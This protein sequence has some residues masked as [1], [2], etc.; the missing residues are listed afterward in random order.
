MIWRVRG[1]IFIGPYRDEYRSDSGDRGTVEELTV[2]AFQRRRDRR[3]PI[4]IR[5]D[6]A[7]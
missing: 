6:T 1:P 4:D 5:R 2:S 7:H 3:D